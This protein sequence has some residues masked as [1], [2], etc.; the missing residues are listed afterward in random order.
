MSCLTIYFYRQGFMRKDYMPLP[1]SEEQKLRHKY[2][3][4]YE[5]VN[6][7]TPSVKDEETTTDD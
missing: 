2:T 7:K 3:G 6:D 1:M 4:L 5:S